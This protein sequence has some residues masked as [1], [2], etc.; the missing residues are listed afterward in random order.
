HDRQDVEHLLSGRFARFGRGESLRRLVRALDQQEL[1]GDGILNMAEVGRRARQRFA[2]GET[3]MTVT[4]LELLRQGDVD[5]HID[6]LSLFGGLYVLGSGSVSGRDDGRE[7]H[8][9]SLPVDNRNLWK[10]FG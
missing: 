5:F 8:L 6:D 3:I 10:S 2:I 7:G 4:R 9:F 1:A